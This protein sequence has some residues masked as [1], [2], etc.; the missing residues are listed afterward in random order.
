MGRVRAWTRG[1]SAE[2]SARGAGG[3][4]CLELVQ[5]A[6][7][8]RPDSQESFVPA[9][10][11]QARGAGPVRSPIAPDCSLLAR[12]AFGARTR[13]SSRRS[14]GELRRLQHELGVTTILVIPRFRRRRSFCRTA[15]PVMSA[16]RIA[17]LG[18]PTEVYQTQYAFRRGLRG[19]GEPFCRAPS[20][21]FPAGVS[22]VMASGV[23]ACAGRGKLGRPDR[24]PG[25]WRPRASA[26]RCAGRAGAIEARLVDR[27]FLGPV[28]AAVGQGRRRHDACRGQRQYGGLTVCPSR[29]RSFPSA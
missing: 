6:S 29:P 3:T 1:A 24:P 15:S 19:S 11:Q 16:R 10:Q 21:R 27:S 28:R 22:F 20:R 4:E 13:P 18:S 2:P 26:D 14:S 12:A 7:P 17:Q 5:L 8:R 9:G 23:R 25:C